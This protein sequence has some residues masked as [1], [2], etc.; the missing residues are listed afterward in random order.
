M[1]HT[2]HN[3]LVDK[4]IIWDLPYESSDV[5]MESRWARLPVGVRVVAG[6]GAL[7]L[8]IGGIVAGI[9]TMTVPS[10][11]H[12]RSAAAPRKTSAHRAAG[13]AAPADTATGDTAGGYTVGDGTAGSGDTAGGAPAADRGVDSHPKRVNVGLAEKPKSPPTQD[14]SRSNGA[15][16][17]QPTRTTPAPTTSPAAASRPSVVAAVKLV[18]TTRT[19]VVTRDVPYTTRIVHVRSL[20]S[21]VQQVLS[22]GAN[23]QQIFRYAVTT[24]NGRE[25]ARRLIGSSTVRQPQSRVLAVGIERD[26]RD[27]DRGTDRGQ[28]AWAWP[29]DDWGDLCDDFCLAAQRSSSEP[30][31]EDRM[32]DFT[33]VGARLPLAVFAGR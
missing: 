25:I 5:P 9:S 27:D 26:H 31:E 14:T 28:Q 22:P 17:P 2:P 3:D 6:I 19:D 8:P 15:A 16:A 21:G 10:D 20:P 29:D 32:P 24:V 18:T 4:G 11:P 12:P 33:E 30:I 7:L 13:Q 1:M 23:G